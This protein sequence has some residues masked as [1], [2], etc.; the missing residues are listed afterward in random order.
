MDITG[1]WSDTQSASSI[2]IA[3][4]GVGRKNVLQSI[5]ITNNS[6]AN[7]LVQSPSGTTKWQSKTF[8]GSGGFDKDWGNEGGV[9]GTENAAL[10]ISVSAG[11][12]TISAS[13]VI[14]G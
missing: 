8:A 10:I 5:N 7:I 1:R 2:T 9:F 11:T 6:A 14:V 13:G 4:P 12:Y 3:A